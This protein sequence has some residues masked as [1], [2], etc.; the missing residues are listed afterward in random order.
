MTFL[1]VIQLDS[2]GELSYYKK[3]ELFEEF[4]G[5]S[6]PKSTVFEH[7]NIEAD[8]YIFEKNREQILEWIKWV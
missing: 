2:I 5:S 1:W 3:S 8:E 6:L 4:T 7:Q